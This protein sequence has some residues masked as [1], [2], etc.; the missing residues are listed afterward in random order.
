MCAGG[1]FRRCQRRVMVFEVVGEHPATMT[2]I[3]NPSAALI[4]EVR[5]A[6]RRWTSLE[7]AV[8]WGL[9]R[10]AEVDVISQDEY[11]HDIRMVLRGGTV[12]L[13]SGR[14]G[15]PMGV[16]IWQIRPSPETLLGR[17]VALGWQPRTSPMAEGDEVLGVAACLL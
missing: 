5:L 4:R 8:L 11:T 16:S 7:A 17:R 10:R 15:D 2:L 14:I 12:V 1:V 6:F 13:D 9:E 3:G